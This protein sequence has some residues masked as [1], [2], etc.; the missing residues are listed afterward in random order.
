MKNLRGNSNMSYSEVAKALGVT[1]DVVRYH[2]NK[3]CP[4]DAAGGAD[5]P[6]NQANPKTLDITREAV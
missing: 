3:K 1:R 6:D 5:Q 4:T 2:L